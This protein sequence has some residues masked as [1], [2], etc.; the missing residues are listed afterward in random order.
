MIYKKIK[1]KFNI[2]KTNKH[3]R[4]F[5]KNIKLKKENGKKILIYAGI[6]EMYISYFEILLYNLLKKEGYD[7]EYLIYNNEIPINEI[8][9]KKVIDGIGKDKFWNNTVNNSI[10]LLKRA[11][12]NYEFISIDK[13]NIENDLRNLKVLKDILSFKKYGINFGK[14]VKGNMYRYYKSLT[15]G[16]DAFEISK[17]M[18]FTALVNY[19]QIKEKTNKN[20]YEYVMF[21]HGIYVTWEPISEFCKLNSIDFIA[22]DRAK[23]KNTININYNQVAPDWSFENAWER[24]R[25]IDL[26]E[27]E[28][29]KV[30]LYLKER[31][32][33]INDVYAYNFSKRSKDLI[34]LKHHLGIPLNAKVV[35][36]F[37]NLIWDAANVSRDLAFKNP[38]ECLIQ[39]IDFFKNDKDVHILL[40]SH[41]A[42]SVLGTQEKYGTLIRDHFEN[43]LPNN[44][45]II[46]PELSINSFSVIDIS[47][48]GIVNT[49][50]VGLEF[51][52]LKKPIILISETHYRNKGFTY[53]VSSKD[54]YF[55]TLKDLLKDQKKLPRQVELAEKY[56]FIMMFKYQQQLPM[57]YNNVNFS[58]YTYSSI[59]DIPKSNNIYKI[60]ENIKNDKKNDFV[61]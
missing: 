7:V 45:T 31:E 30:N 21:S 52:M 1:N 10:N 61:N 38:L 51:A 14:I 29:E 19:Y 36:I 42:E 4:C 44:F 18:L 47:D 11:N 22:Y 2:Y 20:E 13:K 49:S 26:K 9:T 33:Q 60:I 55:K 16:D 48:I 3:I 41:P 15:F 12:V 43:N 50:T 58:N 46:E 6:G 37:T 27:K 28:K 40:R 53:D 35:T 34:E 39:T 8:I 54:E 32:L 59:E 5:F 23:T 24:Y 17:K 25:D 56:F 57:K